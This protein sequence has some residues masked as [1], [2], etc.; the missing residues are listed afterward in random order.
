V[1]ELVR[2]LQHDTSKL[3]SRSASG[4]SSVTRSSGHS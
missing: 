1:V 2:A 3:S 4:G